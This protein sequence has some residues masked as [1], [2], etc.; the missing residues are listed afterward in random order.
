MFFEVC[1]IPSL[2]QQLITCWSDWLV[3]TMHFKQ[4]ILT[5]RESKT[6]QVCLVI[7]PQLVTAV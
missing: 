2:F 4:E 7:I 1:V 6:G 5:K 3:R